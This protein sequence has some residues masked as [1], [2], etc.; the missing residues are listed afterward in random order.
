MQPLF[1]DKL[2]NG[3]AGWDVNE[4]LQVN[5]EAIHTHTKLIRQPGGSKCE[6]SVVVN[7]KSIKANKFAEEKRLLG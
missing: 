1:K 5:P 6:I 3:S 4:S 7:K 2:L